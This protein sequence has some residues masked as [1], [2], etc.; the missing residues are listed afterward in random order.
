MIP[1]RFIHPRQRHEYLCGSKGSCFE[2]Y[3]FEVIC[4]KSQKSKEVKTYLDYSYVF[5]FTQTY[6]LFQRKRVQLTFSSLDRFKLHLILH[7]FMAKW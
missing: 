6:V 5:S 7:F 2:I 3:N 4:Q 1:K